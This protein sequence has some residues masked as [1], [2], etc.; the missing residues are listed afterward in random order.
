[1]KGII[2]AGGTGSRLYPLTSTI[3]KQL[4]P[5][6]DKPMIYY[7]FCT[8]LSCG[9][10]DFCI[11][12]SPEH[13]PSYEKL[14]EDGSQLGVKITYKVQYKPR[15]IAESFIIAEDFIG[16]DN[17]ALILG[18]NIFHGM[19]R[20]KPLLEGAVI[21][22]YEVNDPKA[23]GVLEFDN[24]NN[25]ISIEEKPIEPK[26]NYAVPGLY[27][28]DKKVVQYAKSLKPSNRGEIEITDLN[29]IYLDKK[30]LTAVKF[31]KG[32]AWLD[33]GSAETLFESCAYVQAI[34]SRQGIKIGCIEEECFKRKYISKEQ[35]KALIEKLPNCEYKKYLNKL[36]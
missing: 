12:S 6:Y 25:V 16:D 18:D 33:A 7:P 17:V 31:A 24:E 20:V 19:P 32:T 5:V 15:G 21:F 26:S 30:Q 2:L 11:I 13:L 9:I 36:L 8:L 14:F 35:L 27:F 29:L 23:Y 28:Y 1:M 10:K 22:G 34:Q 3:N 4:L